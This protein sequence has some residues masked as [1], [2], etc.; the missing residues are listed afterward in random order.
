MKKYILVFCS[1]LFLQGCERPN[2]LV[3][4]FLAAGSLIA[5]QQALADDCR[6]G[7]EI[8]LSDGTSAWDSGTC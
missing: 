1:L 6:P 4:G 7:R 2:Q 5:L 8:S 3:V